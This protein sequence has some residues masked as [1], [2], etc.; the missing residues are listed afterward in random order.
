MTKVLRYAHLVVGF[1]GFYLIL[2]FW[3]STVVSELFGNAHQ[4]LIAKNYIL[5]SLW[6][7][8]PCMVMTG[9]SGFQLSKQSKHKKIITKRKRMLWIA[10]NAILVLI[11]CAFYLQNK[12]TLGMFDNA[13]ILVQVIELVVGAINIILFGLNIRDGFIITRLFKN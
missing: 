6:L 11:P 1:L 4:I 5:Y 10:L 9:F 8:I 3:S 2:S 13:F 7:L 12:A